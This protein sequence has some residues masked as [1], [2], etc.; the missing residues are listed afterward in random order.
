MSFDL[1]IKNG[2]IS[3]AKDGSLELVR[4]NDKLRQDIIKILLTSLGENKYHPEYGSNVGSLEIG[5]VSDINIFELDLVSSA[6]DSI[7]KI[8]YLQ[9]SQMKKGQFLSPGE[10][11]ASIKD[12]SIKRDVNDPRLYNIFVS[13]ITQKL[14]QIDEVITVRLI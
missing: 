13:V 14:S 1:K 11:I 9:M 3:L 10:I 4:D 12:V 8:M 7:K 5:Y 2:D 6:E